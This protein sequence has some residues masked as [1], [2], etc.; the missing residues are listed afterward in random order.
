MI[1]VKN[2][3]TKELHARYTE[4]FAKSAER[5]GNWVFPRQIV[6]ASEWL[7]GVE[8]RLG[9]LAGKNIAICWGEKD[10]AFRKK[11]LSRWKRIFP[12]A[13][14]TT[15]HDCGHY[16]AEE[17]PEAASVALWALLAGLRAYSSE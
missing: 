7:A 9:L 2:R 10:L 13:P 17:R 3:L 14:V 15:L 12:D 11:E 4:P 16:V 8:S 6:K 5:K 1:A